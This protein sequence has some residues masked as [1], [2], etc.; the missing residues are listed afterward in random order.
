MRLVSGDLDAPNWSLSADGDGEQEQ[1]ARDELADKLAKMVVAVGT[2]PIGAQARWQSAAAREIA[3]REGVEASHGILRPA[4]EIAWREG[5]EASHGILRLCLRAWREL[6]GG[7][8]AGTAAWEQRWGR[9]F[10]GSEECALACTLTFGERTARQWADE[11]GMVRIMLAWL[12][13]EF[14][15]SPAQ[16]L[17]QCH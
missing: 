9:S 2:W 17:I 16:V 8:R 15:R 4:R 1:R 5:V 11:G 6:K 7:I 12:S 3:W 13:L 10:S 14:A